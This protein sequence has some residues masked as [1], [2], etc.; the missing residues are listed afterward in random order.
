MNSGNLHTEIGTSV[1]RIIKL[2]SDNDSNVCQASINA[3][4]KLV[5]HSKTGLL[6]C[7]ICANHEAS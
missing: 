1:P 7:V 5:E 4:S 6:C 2:L 3:L